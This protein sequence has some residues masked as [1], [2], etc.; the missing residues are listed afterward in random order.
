MLF[1]AC[2][3][4]EMRINYLMYLVIL[5]SLCSV[6]SFFHF[7][8]WTYWKSKL[9][10]VPGPSLSAILLLQDLGVLVANI[11]LTILLQYLQFLYWFG[12]FCCSNS[13]KQNLRLLSQRRRP[14]DA[15]SLSTPVGGP[16]TR[17]DHCKLLHSCQQPNQVY[18][19]LELSLHSWSIT[20]YWQAWV[21]HGCMEKIIHC[22]D[23]HICRIKFIWIMSYVTLCRVQR[24][25]FT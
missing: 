11:I 21:I 23:M 1:S 9:C 2:S 5:S 24:L 12:Q 18:C 14:D 6:L 25:Q 15:D 16:V 4:S 22:C 17:P 13:L 19:R 8:V 20:R 10:Y 7:S 3:H